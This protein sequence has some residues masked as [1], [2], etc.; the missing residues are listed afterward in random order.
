MPRH[1]NPFPGLRSFES[2]DSELF[3]GRES[4]IKELRVKLSMN[5]FLAIVASSGS[6][7]SSLIK[8]G[9]IPSL[10]RDKLNDTAHDEWNVILFKPGATPIRSLAQALQV[11]LYGSEDGYLELAKKIRETPRVVYG[12]FKELIG[13]N[14]LLVIDQ[15]EEVFRYAQP[16]AAE[17]RDDEIHHSGATAKLIALIMDMIQQSDCPVYVVLTM[18]SDYLDE[19]TNYVG[20]TEVINRGYYLLPKMNPAE[21][22]RA[23][24]KPIEL[25]EA[26]IAPDLTDR[27]VTEIGSSFD[28]LPI[29]QHALMR[30]WD[31]WESQETEKPLD[32]THYEAIGTME[33]AV[34]RHAEEIYH[35][36]AN[37]KCRLATEKIFKSLVVLAPG[38]IGVMRPTR[39]RTIVRVTGMER[40]LLT[41]VVNRFRQQGS[42]FLTPSYTQR[43]DSDSFIDISLEKIMTL[44]ERLGG[45]IAEETESAKLY[46]KIGAAAALN[47]AGKTGLLVNPELQLGI[48]W[49]REEHPTL[50][51][52]EKYDPYYERAINYL[53]H[54]RIQ[55]ENAIKNNED[56]QKRELKKA[57][58]FAIVMGMAS[59]LS[60]LFLVISLVLRYDAEQSRKQSLEKEKQ[61]MLERI[62]AEEQ[63][64]ESISQ[65]KIAEQQEIIAEQQRRLTEEQR[66]IAVREQRLAEV[67]RLEAEIAKQIAE[68][69]KVKAD[70]AQRRAE[71][72]KDLAVKSKALADVLRIQADSSRREA[73]LSQKDAEQ[74]RARAVARS[75]AIQSYQMND[76]GQDALPAL[77]AAQAFRFNLRTGG[78]KDNPEIF[79][80]LSNAANAKS[81]LRWH[82]G[83]V[84][85]VISKPGGN[86]YASTG[87]DGTV[88]VWSAEPGGQPKVKSYTANEK[89]AV[90]L[91]SLAF[92]GSG[93]QMFAGSATGKLYIWPTDQI[94]NIPKVIQ[95]HSGIINTVLVGKS[96]EQL[97]SV[98][99]DGSL[100]SWK[101]TPT[102]LDSLQNVQTDIPI[103]C[104]R[105]TPDGGHLACGADKGRVVIFDLQDLSKEPVSFNYYGFGNRVT[106]LAFDADGSHLITGNSAGSLYRWEYEKNEIGRI[107]LP[108]SGRHTSPV[109]EITFSPDGKLVASCS[110]DW[111]VH[112]WNYGNI[113]NRQVQPI[114]LDDF[115]TWVYGLAFSPDG[116]RLVA[117]GADRTIRSWQVDPDELYQKVLEK[118]N[119]DMTIDE[120]NRYI[121]KEIP[122]EKA[123]KS[124]AAVQ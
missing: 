94:L 11:H 67:K 30:T 72:Q 23:I 1:A 17:Q 66:S 112:L 45:W 113:I 35:G 98:G 61:A 87:D 74:Q 56:Q 26:M 33:K 85:N 91:R 16:S 9:L 86:A 123:V 51:W 55:H 111:T 41:E 44:W 106:A 121:G 109:N 6:G 53:D 24:V 110:Y 69:E 59:L 119:R 20:F 88:K 115:D 5:R 76:S 99:D 95:A 84:R 60:L 28:H 108:L 49:L 22:R 63:T 103:L 29:M 47:Q 37:D 38:D 15:F 58:Y 78:Q 2:Q 19:C 52:A 25:Q 64:K 70:S 10:H 14:I 122:Y 18:R 34:S 40:E 100:R 57:R 104:A 80:A 48:Q 102:G 93:D 118:A 36:L 124:D 46:K 92:S 21:I 90:S 32:E 12:L 65:K 114:V 8:A 4:H 54:S 13:K 3:F 82:S 39:L 43:I 81:V 77:L 71:M 105:L 79:K 89:G 75:V 83:M 96:S 42:S 62:R 107:G 97:I 7:K 31:Y 50:E 116:K 120:W 68:I 73:Q 117:G 27:L 101:I